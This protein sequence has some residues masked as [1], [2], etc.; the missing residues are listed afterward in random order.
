MTYK[1]VYDAIYAELI[2]ASDLR[3]GRS[4]EAWILAERE[5]VLREVNR[6]RLLL[7]RVPVEIADV[8]RAE[9]QAVGHSDYI[10]KYAHVAADL[11]LQEPLPHPQCTN[12]T[13]RQR[14]SLRSAN[15]PSCGGS[16][17]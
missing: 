12:P 3:S 10:S 8:T 17:P 6:Q 15:C 1:S 16:Y 9:Q 2:A 5:C 13:C 4:V 14:V 11:V 7:A